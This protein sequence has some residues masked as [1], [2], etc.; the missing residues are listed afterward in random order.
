MSRGGE[1]SLGGGKVRRIEDAR[2]SD[3][4]AFLTGS[5]DKV[6]LPKGKAREDALM[7]VGERI[8]HAKT[9]GE[10]RAC[11]GLLAVG[12]YD[13]DPSVVETTIMT[14]SAVARH[15]DNKTRAVILEMV[16]TKA[17]DE[18]AKVKLAAIRAIGSVTS[19]NSIAEQKAL[20]ET[21]KRDE[22]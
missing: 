13:T 10:K 21:R 2:P 14:L 22:E 19:E 17:K 12:L 6:F 20:L 18:N 1:G 5:G 9:S 7:E 8:A 11:L 3:A 15:V 4:G 16:S